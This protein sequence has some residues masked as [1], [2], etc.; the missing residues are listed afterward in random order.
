MTCIV[1]LCTYMYVCANVVYI[2]YKLATF[3]VQASLGDVPVSKH[4][5]TL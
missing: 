3:L 4:L 5:F 2:M 1:V